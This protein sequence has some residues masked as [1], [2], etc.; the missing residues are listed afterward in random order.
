M[1]HA[2]LGR[3]VVIAICTHRPGATHIICMILVMTNYFV[4]FCIMLKASEI[5]EN[6]LGIMMDVINRWVET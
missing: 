2:G 5:S 3:G 1:G 6:E 4:M